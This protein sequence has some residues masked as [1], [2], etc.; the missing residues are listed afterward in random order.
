[1]PH[2][3][4]PPS[5]PQRLRQVR[6]SPGLPFRELLPESAIRRAL[7]P[8]HAWRDRVFGP[9]V[10]LWAFLSQALDPD[11]SCRQAV[12][13]VNAHRLACGLPPCSPDPSS[14]AQARRRLPPGLP[15]RLAVGAAEQARA[16]APPGWLWRGRRVVI[17]DGSTL[18]LPDTP[19]NQAAYPQPRSQRPGLGSPLMRVVAPFCWAT[20]AV[21]DLA[22]GPHDGGGN[23][24]PSL[25]RRL[26]GAVGPGDVLLAGR[27]FDSYRDVAAVRGRGA[28]AVLRGNAS[29]K[30]G[31]PAGQADWLEVWRRPAFNA[32]RMTRQE[33][34]ALPERLEVRLVRYAVAQAGF[35]TRWVTVVTTPLDA[36]AHPAE[37]LAEL[38]RE[39]WQCEL[40]LRALK[41]ALG[42]E[43][44]RC[45]TPALVEAEVWAH[46]L[47]YNLLRRVMAEAALAHGAA[48]RRLSFTGALQAAR[49]PLQS[50]IREAVPAALW[51]RELHRQIA[52][53]R[54]GGR[55]D[56]SEPR[57]V[58]RR[59]A[60]YSYLTRP[61]CE[62][63][64][65]P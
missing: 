37:A 3:T 19:A 56:R 4:A 9:F 6:S 14:H 12:A 17:A 65:T 15:R 63:R 52:H 21:L 18:R 61:R 49:A 2:A 7:P 25:F 27:N 46:L 60:R 43:A 33:H 54:I 42:M 31:G 62:E 20:G 44:M 23:G 36:Q 50:G 8:G 32:R 51:R 55:P 24:E 39:R 22:G 58:K 13:R 16:L 53:H 47:G 41:Q 64:S 48:A 10:T 11:R 34:A 28:G 38:Y 5:L 59:R 26:L 40:H 57:K 29:R 1:M 35:R 45:E 30:P